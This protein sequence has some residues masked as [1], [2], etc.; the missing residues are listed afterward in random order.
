MDRHPEALGFAIAHADLQVTPL[1]GHWAHQD[2]AAP[3]PAQTVIEK[4]PRPSIVMVLDRAIA[5][6]LAHAA[7]WIARHRHAA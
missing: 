5:H 2:A 1:S 6:E 3:E 4:D 7:A